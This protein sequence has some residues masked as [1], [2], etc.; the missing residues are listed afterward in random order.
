MCQL[1]SSN[2]YFADEGMAISEGV[3]GKFGIEMPLYNQYCIYSA[4][5]W[6]ELW[7]I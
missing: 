2:K 5:M 6:D 1:S 7:L 4:F 3:G